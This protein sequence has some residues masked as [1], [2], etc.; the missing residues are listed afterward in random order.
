MRVRQLLGLAWRES[1]TARRRLLLYMSSISLGVAALVAIDSFASNTQRSVREQARALLGG[2]IA[3]HDALP[4]Y[5]EAGAP[6]ARLARP[7]RRR[8]SPQVTTFASMALVPAHRRHA[9]RRRSAPS[10]RAIRSTARSSRSPAGE[11]ARLHAGR[12]ALVDPVAA[13]RARRARRRH[14]HAR[15][16]ALRHRRHARERAG[17]RRRHARRSARASTSP[18][19]YLDETSLLLFGSR[20]EY[21]TLVKLPPALPPSRFIFR[22]QAA[23]RGGAA[24]ATARAARDRVQPHRVDRPA[25]RLPR[26]HR[27]RRAA[28]RRHRRGER[29]ATRSSCGRS[30]RSPS[31]AASARRAGRCSRSTCCRRR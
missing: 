4:D 26:R 22:I 20:A 29:R 2:D 9:A 27:P 7:R 3:L 1:R 31:C 13:R 19:A 30:T 14:A 25:A 15:L 17:R 11:W 8:A 10:R 28:A 12:D 5:P 24:C 16:R 23:A 21:E 6:R 18:R